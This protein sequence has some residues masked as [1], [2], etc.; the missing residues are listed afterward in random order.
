MKFAEALAQ[1]R[2]LAMLK[3]IA[4]A[5]GS[6]N[7]RVLKTGLQMLGHT[8]GLTDTA[9]RDE[10]RFLEDAG[11]VRLEWFADKIAVAHITRRGIDCAEGQIRVDGVKKP[12]LGL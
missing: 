1:D 11:C 9:V 8:A 7:E 12:S 4:E 3:L 2:R 10:L 6:A 5:D